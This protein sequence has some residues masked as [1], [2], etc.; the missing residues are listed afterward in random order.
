EPAADEGGTRSTGEA[1]EKLR[2]RRGDEG[3]D[4]STGTAGEKL[5]SRREGE[6]GDQAAP[7]PPAPAAEPAPSAVP[8][9]SPSAVPQPSPGADAELIRRRWSEVL[10][11]LAGFKRSTWALVSQNAQVAEVSGGVLHLAFATSGLAHTF[12]NGAHA[13]PLQRALAETLGVQ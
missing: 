3:G 11:T 10:A 12:R 2:S 6:G 4:R 7:E 9:P 13:D 1:G 5:R 8:Q